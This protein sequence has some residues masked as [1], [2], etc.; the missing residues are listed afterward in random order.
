MA[1]FICP[2]VNGATSPDR[3]AELILA[4]VFHQRTNENAQKF[5]DTDGTWYRTVRDINNI[6]KYTQSFYIQSAGYAFSNRVPLTSTTR[7]V[8]DL[9]TAMNMTIE[10]TDTD[11]NSHTWYAQSPL[12]LYRLPYWLTIYCPDKII[13]ALPKRTSTSKFK[14]RFDSNQIIN[15]MVSDGQTVGYDGETGYDYTISADTSMVSPGTINSGYKDKVLNKHNSLRDIIDFQTGKT[16][17]ASPLDWVNGPDGAVYIIVS[18]KEAQD[19][20]HTVYTAVREF[21]AAG[22]YSGADV[23][24]VKVQL[25]LTPDTWHYVGG[26]D[27]LGTSFANSW[28]NYGSGINNLRF[29]KISTN[30]GISL[31]AVQI[32]GL[33]KS[34]TGNTVFTLPTGYIP[35]AGK[36]TVNQAWNG[37]TRTAGN[38]TINTSG[39]VS[40]TQSLGNTYQSIDV[41]LYL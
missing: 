8:Q 2:D 20:A 27:A 29:K 28:T 12:D 21:D 41:I 6:E 18:K 31:D 23:T 30:G 11:A 13:L 9:A 16:F 36:L 1:R 3:A 15:R 26:T 5:G 10:E 32:E 7:T 34:G 39:V 19:E 35:S 24:P 14:G 22:S 25:S 40:V 37:S 17:D 38:V 33:V 4:H